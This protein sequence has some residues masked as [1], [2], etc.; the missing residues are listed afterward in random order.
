[1]NYNRN[2]VVKLFFLNLY[3]IITSYE[4]YGKFLKHLWVYINEVLMSVWIE[5]L[6]NKSIFVSN[7]I[8]LYKS[9]IKMYFWKTNLTCKYASSTYE[10]V[11]LTHEHV[12]P[13][14]T[15]K[16]KIFGTSLYL[17]FSR[18]SLVILAYFFSANPNLLHGYCKREIE[19]SVER[20]KYQFWYQ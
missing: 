11:S 6:S 9:S 19:L 10:Y 20:G 14:S 2:V 12:L 15:C 18:D 13:N 7:I 4:K 16:Y 17:I 5:F 8:N 3:R 1:M